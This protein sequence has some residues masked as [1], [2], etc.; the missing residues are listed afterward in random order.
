[1][2]SASKSPS[3]LFVASEAYPYSKETGVADVAS[4]LPIAIRN[5]GCD[6]RVMVP[7]YGCTSSNRNK[8]HDINRLK[9]IPIISSSNPLGENPEEVLTTKSSSLVSSKTKVQVYIATNNK[10]FDSRNG[11]YHDPV[12]WIEYPDNLERFVFFCRSIVETCFTLGWFPD[13]IHCNDWQTAL[14]PVFIRYFY[15]SKFKKTKS[16]LTIHNITNQGKF[17]LSKF[18]LLGL[19]EEAKE[20]F[21]YQKSLNILKAG[22]TYANYITTVS[23]TY[24][25]EILEDKNLTQGLSN[26][27]KKRSDRI[28]GIKNGIDTLSWN[29]RKDEL[30][31]VRLTD[32]FEAYKDGNKMALCDKCAIKYDKNIPIIGMITNLSEQKGINLVIDAIPELVKNKLQLIILGQGSADIKNKLIKLQQKYNKN[33]HISFAFDDYFAHLLEAGSD[34]YLM[35]S[36]YEACGLNLFYSFTYGTVP[37]VNLTGGIKDSAIPYVENSD[38]SKANSIAMKDFSVKSLLDAI[39]KANDLFLN[40]TEWNKLIKNGMEGDYSWDI[41]ARTYVDIYKRISKED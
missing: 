7:K 40:K 24:L 9:N 8:I 4:S 16:L 19:P 38:N 2:A 18:E 39:K 36:Q 11:I 37:V 35:P 28:T 30:I 17:P 25:K 22:I 5:L 3:V 32:D 27:L 31:P 12:K 34:I 29:P 10:F 15:P 1:M 13:I 14:V 20:A 26:L 41:S 33:L 6:I 23:K 21:N